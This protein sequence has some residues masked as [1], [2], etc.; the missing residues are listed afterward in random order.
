MPPYVLAF[1]APCLIGVAV[2]VAVIRANKDDLPAIVGALMRVE[3]R[4]HRRDVDGLDSPS[5]PER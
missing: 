5:L 2:I 4:A 1:V 3:P